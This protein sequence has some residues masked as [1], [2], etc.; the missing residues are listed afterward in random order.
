MTTKTELIQLLNK[1]IKIRVRYDKTEKVYLVNDLNLDNFDTIYFSEISREIE[2]KLLYVLKISTDRREFLKEILELL[3]TKIQW[4]DDNKISDFSFIKKFA[5][6]IKETNT[7]HEL[8]NDDYGLLFLFKE[9]INQEVLGDDELFKLLN[10]LQQ[11]AE[12]LSELYHSIYKIEMEVDTINFNELI[13]LNI[14]NL[15]QKNKLKCNVNLDKIT[16]AN[17][18]HILMRAGFLSIDK[19]DPAN[20]QKLMCEFIEDN[21][22]YTN[23]KNEKHLITNIYKEFSYLD[24]RGHENRQRKILAMLISTLEQELNNV[25]KKRK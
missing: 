1:F 12:F 7:G 17:F 9:T 24:S 8:T 19:N 20:N 15:Q 6:R 25:G 13:S 14:I 2:T 18:F 3:W 23:D 5:L 4:Y 16:T 22:T 11:H 10:V 21:F